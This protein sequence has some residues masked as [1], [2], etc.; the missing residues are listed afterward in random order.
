MLKW[1][2]TIGFLNPEKAS[3][4]EN[5]IKTHVSA[6]T[7][8]IE[9]GVFCGK[10]LM[11]LLE[12]GNPKHVFAID[13]FEGNVKQTVNTI[14]GMNIDI[15]YNMHYKYDKVLRRFKDFDNVTFYKEY[16]PLTDQTFPN[17]GYAYIDGN[18]GKQ[19]VLDD[20]DWIYSLMSNGVIVFDDYAI[21]GVK[22]AVSYFAEKYKLEV[23]LSDPTN[24]ENTIAW[25]LIEKG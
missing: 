13:P 14:T 24:S 25:I 16:S 4:I 3:I 20:A 23:C 21:E 7:N 22:D 2:S 9:V 1:Q 6:D 17:I 10:S 12:V 19:E 11:H 18:H 15:D 5:L 8:C